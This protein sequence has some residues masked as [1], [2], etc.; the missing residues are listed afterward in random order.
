MIR[1]TGR[2]HGANI[3]RTEGEMIVGATVRR[4]DRPHKP[5]QGNIRYSDGKR[6]S[7]VFP[8]Q[9]VRTKADAL[10]ALNAWRAELE[11]PSSS[12]PVGDYCDRYIEAIAPTLE[13]STASGYAHSIA[14]VREMGPVPLSKV[15][16]GMVQRWESAM[17]S[18]GLS[19][20][21][22]G[23]AHRLLKQVMAHAVRV[24]D[25][26]RN[27]LDDVKPPK[28]RAP[29]PNA[30]DREGR[31]R[32]IS[33]LD[34]MGECPLRTAAYIA[35]FTG[36]RRG[37]ICALRW[38]DFGDEIAVRRS[39]GIGRGGAYL[40]APKSDAGKRSI[41]VPERLRTVV[42]PSEGYVLGGETFYNPTKLGKE[43]AAFAKSFGIIGMEGRVCTFH[44]LRHTYATTAI[45][46]GADVRSVASILGHSNPAMTLTVY[47]AADP[48]AR[49]RVAR[50]VGE[51][52]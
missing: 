21:T 23:K 36:M 24:G 7:K 47:A 49:R 48:E 42:R 38:D 40:K 46:N 8:W 33:L 3:A 34:S 11:E 6:V 5:W 16:A 25:I 13:R 14:H 28:R 31:A 29:S 22:V 30:L 26:A 1:P 52:V 45:A 41:P 2:E 35:L 10:K 9:I 39:V 27:P 15:S 19:S 50:I 37:E 17:L 43:W 4:L 51:S 18:R 32:L 12:M 20:S 44:D